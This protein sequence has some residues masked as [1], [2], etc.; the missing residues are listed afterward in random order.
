MA[1][2][3]VDVLLKDGT[4]ET[5]FINDVTSNDEVDLKNRL[6][7]SPTFVVLNVEESYFDTLRSHSSV[8][9][10][11]VEELAPVDVVYPDE[12]TKVTIANKSIGGTTY[13]TNYDGRK[14]LSFQHYLDTDI[15]PDPSPDRTV[16]VGATTYTGHNVGSNY[17]YGAGSEHGIYGARDQI[18][19][20]GSEPDSDHGQYPDGQDNDYWTY[21]TGK[22]VDVV[23]VEGGANDDMHTDSSYVAYHQ[24]PEWDDL[25]NPGQTRVIPMD[26]PNTDGACNSQVSTEIALNDHATGTLSVSCGLQGG[27]AKKAK[28]R[29]IYLNS[30]DGITTCLD[31]VKTWHNAKPNNPETGLPDPTVL[32][33]EWHHPTTNNN[34]AIKIEDIDS[35]TDPTS[36][37][38]SAPDG[39]WTND[40]TAFTS[41]GMIPF[42]LKDPDDNSWHWVMTFPYQTQASY[43]TSF[44][45][46]WDAGIIVINAIGNGGG[47]YVHDDDPRWNGSYCTISGSKT[48]YTMD[49]GDAPNNSQNDPCKITKSTTT[50]TTWYKFRAYGPGG[51]RKSINVAAGE[52]SEGCPTL[53]FYTSRGPA[54]DVIG[55]GNITFCAGTP[56]DPVFSDGNRWGV[57]GGTSCAKPT[58]GGK[59]ACVME[60]HYMKNGV[61]PTPDE[62][63]NTMVAEARPTN[64]SIR[65]VDWSNVPSPSDTD[66]NPDQQSSNS[67]CLK[68]KS[69]TGGTPPNGGW[70]FGD[71]AGTTNLQAFF[72]NQGF[73][74]EHTHGKRPTSGVLYPRPRKFRYPP[75]EEAAT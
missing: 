46:A 44:E 8:V 35:V 74:R 4:D 3:Q 75:P 56:T 12:P 69:G 9:S 6:P 31:S 7:S 66:I 30:E 25:D 15:I 40:F 64:I 42:Q 52:N 21:Y 41:R 60:R 62:V 63:K 43:H 36:G 2:V 65:T 14:M 71:H 19:H 18:R 70:R 13:W 57:F 58:V 73:N 55:R 53:N 16:G 33:T 5:A 72:N 1:K 38:T 32:V 10:V 23:V 29:A 61:W 37:I 24:H 28:A 54:V 39:G 22:N 45:Q 51:T 47:I 48:L 67:P 49:Y 50:T 68:I 34:Y 11:Q 20:Y 27:F 26:W 17:Y 59:A